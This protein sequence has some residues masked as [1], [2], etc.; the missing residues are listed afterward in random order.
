[1]KRLSSSLREAS[2]D[3]N[4]DG[5]G[6]ELACLWTFLAPL[7]R[8][9][10]TRCT[11]D[12]VGLLAHTIAESLD[13]GS[14]VQKAVFVDFSSA[15]NAIPRSQILSILFSLHTDSLTS[16][17]CRLLKYADDFVLCNSYNKAMKVFIQALLIS[18]IV[19]RIAKQKIIS[20]L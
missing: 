3:E 9:G 14:K 13:G 2:D 17:H 10:S 5:E 4:I 6:G 20:I 7:E 15:F 1:M 18:T 19:V 12:S 11:L 16:R 8:V